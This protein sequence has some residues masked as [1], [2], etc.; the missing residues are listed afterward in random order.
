M[1]RLLHTLVFLLITLVFQTGQAAALSREENQ[2]SQYILQQKEEQLFMLE[3]LV[4]INSGTTNVAGVNHVGEILRS[5]LNQLG[6]KTRW[7]QEPTNMHR[8]PTLVAERYGTTGK[9]LLL[10]GHLDTV[11]RNDNLFQKFERRGNKVTGPGVIDDKGG[12]VVILYALKALQSIHALDNA[13]ITVVLTGDEE[14]SGKPTSISRKPL[15][16]AAYNSDIA[17]D[18]ESAI[19]SDTATVA[20]RGIVNWRIETQGTAAHSSEIFKKTA[21]LG[22]I[23][24]LTR[25]LDT[26]RTQLAGEKYLSFSP[27]IIFG[28]TRIH[29]D[30]NNSEGIASGKD[31]VI[32]K[33]AIAKG[34]LRF[35]S[36]D[37]KSNAENKILAIVSQHLSGTTASIHFQEGIPGMIPTENNNKLLQKYS[38]VSND[39]GY[40]TMTSLDPGMRGAGDISHIASI[41]SANL[42]GLGALGAG[43]HSSKETVDINSLHIQTQRAAILI[44]RLTRE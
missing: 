31:N 11:F 35:L 13:A 21:G 30:Q 38:S 24:E 29:Y 26:M 4:N 41:V 2:I 5:Q 39:L 37:Q 23:F 33:S 18:F 44:Y 1:N 34:D 25:I 32:A 8:A 40:G 3:K 20:R 10:I 14:D 22:A 6:F 19:T 43:A 7:V 42:A 36:A 28:G 15:F 17:L 16:D 27:G 9:R 12:D